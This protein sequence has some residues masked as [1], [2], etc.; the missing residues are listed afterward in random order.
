MI[1]GLAKPAGEKALFK[2]LTRRRALIGLSTIGGLGSLGLTPLRSIALASDANQRDPLLYFSDYFSFVG[3]DDEGW[4]HFAIDN[5]RGRAGDSYQADHFIVMHDERSG[6]VSLQ[7]SQHYENNEK[8]LEKIPDSTHFQFRGSPG[9]G[10]TMQSATNDLHME[11]EPVPKTL[12]RENAD[13]IFWVGASP[14]TLSWNKRR[15]EGRVIVEYLQRHNW[16][17]FVADFAAH[18]RNFNGL[19]LMTDAGHDFYM[20][21][22]E[23]IGGS[24]LNGRLVGFASWATPAPISD[25]DFRVLR[26]EPADGGK[27]NWPVDWRVDFGH[28]GKRYRLSLQ[29]REQLNI[30]HWETGGF[31]MTVATGAIEAMEGSEKHNVVGWA[32]L[33]I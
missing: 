20:H 17:R 13:G 8:T 16:N 31:A 24:D 12:Y 32:E 27:Y 5:N 33:L 28:N 30:A 7:G 3:R 1:V 2:Y 9:S 6:W 18:W 15:L 19:Y 25:L 14:A 29:R 26:S 4:V 22:H 21:Y 10:T 23:R 11:V